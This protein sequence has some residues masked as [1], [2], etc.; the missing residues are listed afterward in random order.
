M[1]RFW[2]SASI[3]LLVMLLSVVFVACGYNGK[4]TYEESEDD[5]S[6]KGVYTLKSNGSYTLKE[7]IEMM[8]EK[9]SETETGTYVIEGEVIK[10]T[11]SEG[12][13]YNGKVV[14]KTITVNEK[15]FTK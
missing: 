1:K 4:Y 7:D 6:Y 3:I 2:F 14:N 9:E 8:G 12:E 10:F 5:F 13:S 11:P 15:E